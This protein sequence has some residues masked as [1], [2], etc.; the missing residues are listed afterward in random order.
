VSPLPQ[1]AFT[2]A[3][4]IGQE[5]FYRETLGLL[6]R[7]PCLQSRLKPLPPA[8]R[9]SITDAV[10]V[11]VEGISWGGAVDGG[12]PP[13]A[14]RF[15]PDV[16]RTLTHLGAPREGLSVAP[17]AAGAGDGLPGHRERPAH[18]TGFVAQDFFWIA[19]AGSIAAFVLLVFR[20]NRDRIRAAEAE[21]RLLRREIAALEPSVARLRGW[22]RALA[23]GDPEAWAAVAR[24]RGGWVGP[25]EKMM[26]PPPPDGLAE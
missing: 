3:D 25:G 8:D 13:F 4:I 6:V 2:C 19:L 23:A 9:Y 14:G 5:Q 16:G 21:C 18:A 10:I 24:S 17:G 12:L 7:G 11:T 1:I 15:A 22:E 26:R 20:P